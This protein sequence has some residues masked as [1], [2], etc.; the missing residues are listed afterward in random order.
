MLPKQNITSN[1]MT[2]TIS[3]Q[4]SIIQ[5]NG[6]DLQKILS[7]VY[8]QGRR[9]ERDRPE[10]ERIT[11]LSLSKELESSGRKISPRTLATKAKAANV[12]LIRFDGNKLAVYR[13]DIKHFIN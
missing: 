5:I 6:V 3:V 7:E 11:L 8:N 4:N 13:N 2:A 9:D 12:K 10:P 1:L